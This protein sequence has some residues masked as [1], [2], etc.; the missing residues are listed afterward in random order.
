MATIVTTVLAALG[1]FAWGIAVLSAFRIVSLA[2]EGQKLSVYGQVGWWQFDKIRAALGPDVDP[3]IRAYQRAFLTF[4][5]CV[6]I[7][8]VAGTLFAAQAQN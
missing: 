5:G 8:M 1:F 4:I 7:A 6:L 3:H 2:P